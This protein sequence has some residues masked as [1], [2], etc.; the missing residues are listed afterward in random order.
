MISRRGLTY[1][2]VGNSGSGKSTLAAQIAERLGLPHIELDA[3]FHLAGWQEPS[4][5]QFR[6]AVA[7]ALDAHPNGWVVDGNYLSRLGDVLVAD[8]TVWLDYR[9]WV[10]GPRIVRRTL[11]R[12]VS[13]Q[14][15]W[16]GNRERWS[17]ML[18]RDPD[19]NVVLWSFM[20]H[21]RYRESLGA[22]RAADAMGTWVVLRSPR[23]TRRWLAG[24][25]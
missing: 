11:G 13:R 10:V 24:L 20:Q 8:T 17:A 22:A 2:I 16:N 1:R 3:L 5:D 6:A 21:R 9:R 25:G 14:E 4:V 18:S 12:A 19:K 7:S 23:E 15:L